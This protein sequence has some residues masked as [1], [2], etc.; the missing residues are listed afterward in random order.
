MKSKVSP[1]LIGA[2]IVGAL[3]LAVVGVLLFGSGRLFRDT[4][5]CVMYFDGD[6]QGLSVGAAVKFRGVKIGEV[7]SIVTRIDRKT[8]EVRIPVHVDLVDPRRQLYGRALDGE[9]EDPME[10]L[11]ARG[12]RAQL[13][14]E[15]LVTGQLFVQL[16]FY[17]DAPPP[18]SPLIDRWS[19]RHV[20]PTVPTILQKAQTTLTEVLEK[21]EKLPLEEMLEALRGTLA[22]ADRLLNSPELTRAPAELTATLAEIRRVATSTERSLAPL[23]ANADAAARSVEASARDLRPL[24]ASAQRAF[25]GVSTF[26]EGDGR[27]LADDLARAAAEARATLTQTRETMASLEALT[28]PTSAAGHQLRTALAELTAAARAIRALADALEAQPNAVIFG[29]QSGREE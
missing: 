8:L 16:D 23:L 5:P 14:A 13:Q 27:R 6:V 18:R 28:L 21:V 22:G 24:A 1:T 10:A 12:L 7:T 9:P 29:K 15:S 11:V 19:K 17:P 4:V 2:F 3:G 20:I 25:D 26:A